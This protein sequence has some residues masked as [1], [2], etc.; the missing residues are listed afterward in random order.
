LK[1]PP[2]LHSVFCSFAESDVKGRL[3]ETAV[4]MIAPAPRRTINRDKGI[5]PIAERLGRLG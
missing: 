4:A 1:S 5:V 2:T 3:H